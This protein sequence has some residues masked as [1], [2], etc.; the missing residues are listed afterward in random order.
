MKEFLV[1]NFS[2][3]VLVNIMGTK[4]ILFSLQCKNFSQWKTGRVKQGDS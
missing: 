4:S 3:A 2:E 1:D